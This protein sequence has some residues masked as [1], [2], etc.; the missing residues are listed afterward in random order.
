MK[1]HNLITIR[2]FF[3]ALI[4]AVILAACGGGGSS[5]TSAGVV[6]GT[7]STAGGVVGGT[8]SG[9][10]GGVTISNPVTPPIYQWSAS[11]VSL[12]FASTQLGGTSQ[13]Q[14][15]TISNTG[16]ANLAI[17]AISTNDSAWK[18]TGG[19]CAIGTNLAVTA[20]CTLV[21]AF[22]PSSPSIYAG[23]ITLSSN[24]ISTPLAIA[25]KSVGTA[26]MYP[27]GTMPSLAVSDC[28]RLISQAL[29]V[30]SLVLTDADTQQ[31]S[32]ILQAISPN[33]GYQ[34][35]ARM[36]DI[37]MWWVRSQGR[38][39]NFQTLGTAT[40]ETNHTFDNAMRSICNTD[41]K[42]RLSLGSVI[43]QTDLINGNGS[44]QP[45]IIANQTIPANLKLTAAYSRYQTYIL[46]SG[47]Y[48]ADDFAI[49]L[50]EFNAYT[51]GAEFEIN[52]LS[53]SQYS[54][55]SPFIQANVQVDSNAG[56]MA[57]FMMYTL[58]YL[59]AARLNYPVTYANIQAQPHTIAY[60][61]SVWNT[62]EAN[63]VALYPYTV[64]SGTGG[65]TVSKDA[66]AAAYSASFINELD[67]LG[68]T[69]SPITAWTNTYLH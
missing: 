68:I 24:S 52:L 15:V 43:N 48:P 39:I 2:N 3:A 11:Q 18:I 40:H 9:A 37:F 20:T 41:Q 17:T 62:A 56:G 12:V 67:R 10:S 44:T 13:N 16:T 69:H 7:S 14:T 60:I 22:S 59:Q 55:L 19:S 65:M 5:S 23:S 49:L 46:G 50:D 34:I 4:I 63:L 38:G 30:S 8:S 64:I 42:A 27:A 57:D 54:P 26:V 6:G 51:D 36:P 35:F 25:L 53:N 1:N 58:A 47:A 66:L 32:N 31:V 21:A 29:A 61:Q 45:Y 28:P 33:H